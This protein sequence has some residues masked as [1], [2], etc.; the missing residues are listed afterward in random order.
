MSSVQLLNQCLSRVKAF[1]KRVITA[2]KK[3]EPKLR[4]TKKQEVTIRDL[5]PAQDARGGASKAG[6]G[7]PT[8]NRTG[9]IDFMKDVE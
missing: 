7:R 3:R 8:S 6:N 4:Q 5:K 1:V 9:E 2:K